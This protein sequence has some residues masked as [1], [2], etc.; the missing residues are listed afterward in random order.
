MQPIFMLYHFLL[1]QGYKIPWNFVS[2]QALGFSQNIFRIATEVIY[3][4]CR[5]KIET[6]NKSIKRRI[7][8]RKRK[9]NEIV[10]EIVRN[11]KECKH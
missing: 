6:M 5:K 4:F 3:F 2:C 10:E 1:P 7:R 8:M 9:K 11:T